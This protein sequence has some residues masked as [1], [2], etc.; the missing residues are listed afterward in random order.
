ML[1][2]C[3]LGVLLI[4]AAAW[5]YHEVEVI[6]IPTKEWNVTVALDTSVQ[7]V[8]APTAKEGDTAEFYAQG[9]TTGE[10][11][12]KALTAAVKS[13]KASG[14]Q[15]QVVLTVRDL[16]PIQTAAIPDRDQTVTAGSLK[17]TVTMAQQVPYFDMLYLQAGVVGLILVT[18][19]IM[20]YWLVGI[21]EGSVEFLIATDGEMKKVNWSTRKEVLGSTWV[22]IGA[23]FLIAAFLFVIDISFSALFELIGLLKKS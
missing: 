2:A 4:S 17:G 22:V 23:C 11:G 21:K 5:A 15:N 12:P 18:G 7:N 6:R 9:A 1:T 3:L 10:A 20:I 8:Q 16:S 19:A 13:L 14:G